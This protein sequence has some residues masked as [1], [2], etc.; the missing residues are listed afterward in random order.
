[1]ADVLPFD[2]TNI[3]SVADVQPRYESKASVTDVV[4]VLV[5]PDVM[6][7]YAFWHV[8]NWKTLFDAAGD[9]HADGKNHHGRPK[10][11]AGEALHNRGVDGHWRKKDGVNDILRT[12]EPYHPDN[13][14]TEHPF[15][16][17]AFPSF[18]VP[19]GESPS[20]ATQ[21]ESLLFVSAYISDRLARFKAFETLRN[22]PNF[23]Y[24]M[25]SASEYIQSY[26]LDHVSALFDQS[27]ILSGDRFATYV[28]T[29][30]AYGALRSNGR[31]ELKMIDLK[32]INSPA[33]A[34]SALKTAFKLYDS[35]TTNYGIGI[36]LEDWERVADLPELA[37]AHE[38]IYAANT[39][40]N[41]FSRKY[42]EHKRQA[43]MYVEAKSKR[44][45]FH[46]RSPV[47]EESIKLQ[48]MYGNALAGLQNVHDH[49]VYN[50]SVKLGQRVDMIERTIGK[51]LLAK[52]HRERH[53]DAYAELVEIRKVLRAATN[54]EHLHVNN[55]L[56]DDVDVACARIAE[57]CEPEDTSTAQIRRYN[58][59]GWRYE[60]YDGHHEKRF[61]RNYP[62]NR[63]AVN[64]DNTIF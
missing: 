38:Y 45:E 48:D 21:D 50:L 30:G 15:M 51:P 19:L 37:L 58:Y 35:M 9:V 11:D 27:L 33:I 34:V 57:Y 61:Y 24:W 29:E 23:G 52:R 42:A 53:A 59:H 63:E 43:D 7:S 12:V 22:D 25:T 13:Y 4:D 26:E 20:M 62:P 8:N 28:R 56:M 44:T 49:A 60:G 18:G 2:P 1:M 3:E 14:Q 39:M 6:H 46:E 16:P 64:N 41:G 17:P 55:V 47:T 36:K 31:R 54:I 40:A 5:D 10:L 32:A